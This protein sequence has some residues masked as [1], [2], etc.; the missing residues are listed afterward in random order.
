MLEMRPLVRLL[1]AT[2]IALASC[3]RGES[4]DTGIGDTGDTGDTGDV[5]DPGDAT[6]IGCNGAAWARFDPDATSYLGLL[7][8]PDGDLL[9]S[10]ARDQGVVVRWGADAAIAGDVVGE[11]AEGSTIAL[12]GVDDQG[13]YAIAHVAILGHHCWYDEYDEEHC[14]TNTESTIRLHGP[15]D[16]LLWER[17]GDRVVGVRGDGVVVGLAGEMLIHYGPTGEVLQSRPLTDVVPF[18][19]A[20]DGG[21]FATVG[22]AS[23]LAR[24]DADLAVLWSVNDLGEIHQITPTVDGGLVIGGRTP[25]G[26]RLI[27][28]GPDGHELWRVDTGVRSA[29]SKSGVSALAIGREGEIAAG[30]LGWLGLFSADGQ[31]RW[32]LRCQGFDAI[33]GLAVAEGRIFVAGPNYVAAWNHE[34]APELLAFCGN[35]VIDDGET[36]DLGLDNGFSLACS[37]DCQGTYCGNGLQ[38]PG[39]GCDDGLANSDQ[40]ACTLACQPAVCGDG[41]VHVGV[42]GC[43]GGD[44]CS[45]SC[46][47][48]PP[49]QPCADPTICPYIVWSRGLVGV[50]AGVTQ[51][52]A[53]PG[54]A[55]ILGGRLGWAGLD[56]GGDVIGEGILHAD[57]PALFAAHL[58]PAGEHTS[59]FAHPVSGAAELHALVLAPDGDLVVA[60]EFSGSI[61][62][63]GLSI[64]T[65][66][67]ASELFVARLDPAGVPRWAA[68]LGG[69]DDR[70]PRIAAAV[71]NAGELVLAGA[72]T[73]TLE[74]GDTSHVSEGGLD[75]FVA[76]LDP[77]GARL[78]SAS[79]GDADDQEGTDVAVDA[80][81]VAVITGSFFGAID[82]GGDPLIAP[83]GAGTR[84]LARLDVDG[85]HL[86]SRDL[87][88]DGATPVRGQR[89]LGID[90]AGAIYLATD[91]LGTIDLG[92]GPL[93]S[94]AVDLLVAKLAPDGA[95]LWSKLL[96]GTASHYSYGLALNPAGEL[97]LTGR[98][99]GPI[100]FGGGPIASVN[101]GFVAR[102]GPDGEHRWSLAIPRP[103]F[104][105]ATHVETLAVADD[106]SVLV[107]GAYSG[108]LVFGG[109]SL[110]TPNIEE[111]HPFVARLAA[112]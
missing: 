103:D 105:S 100:D 55:P 88:G 96:G 35:Q 95:V 46:H 81:G 106:G 2:L 37:V 13:R 30:G 27:R 51:I 80:G 25:D 75:L 72:F 58:T 77:T 67:A 41:R 63:G 1:P 104:T 99:D 111:S 53:G 102:L 17:P 47:V 87:G 9:V 8:T 79:F 97:A 45:P 44:L 91:F 49:D 26:P 94:K 19:L 3:H 68:A 69:R 93:T 110:V 109:P 29:E 20:P 62:F 12:G 56:L 40:G 34:P 98:G 6:A 54:G 5:I 60:G 22:A 50:G 11:G 112:P 16:A 10:G 38:D 43:D 33:A 32:V 70:S 86:W 73:G 84:L 18:A 65:S 28:I 89:H 52:V 74:V 61:D 21:Y 71:D 107:G 36:C 83:P 108:A 23:D 66:L 85:S 4:A 59:S 101:Y 14:T 39:E 48:E 76:R 15:G 82:L 57:G 31:A 64:A 90:D 24:V 42:E 92:D 7:R 78:W